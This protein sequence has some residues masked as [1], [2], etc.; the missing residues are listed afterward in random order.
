MTGEIRLLNGSNPLSGR[1]EV[2]YDGVWGTVCSDQW[3]RADAMVAC[4]QLGFSSLGA[5]EHYDAAFGEG[6]GVVLLDEVRCTGREYTLFDCRN[7]GLTYANCGH[8]RDAGVVCVPGKNGTKL[9]HE[10]LSVHISGCA[11]GEIRLVG[12]ANYTE[13]RV[14]ICLNN[15]WGTVCDQMWNST[16]SQV[17]CRQLSLTSA[18]TI[19]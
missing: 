9:L 17:V 14:E 1:V 8:N 15:E 11:S 13:G 5:I 3:S 2:C 4:R 19:P 18:G 6:T 10:I 7:S 12:G 16:E